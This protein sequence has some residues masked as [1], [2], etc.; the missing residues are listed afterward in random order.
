MNN[1]YPNLQ[2]QVRGNEQQFNQDDE[3]ENIDYVEDDE[4]DNVQDNNNQ[5]YGQNIR[6]SKYNQDVQELPAIDIN[7][8]NNY[9]KPDPILEGL[10]V[11]IIDYSSKTDWGIVEHVL[12]QIKSYKRGRESDFIIVQR[13]YSDFEWL[14][15]EFDQKYIGII[16]PPLPEKNVLSKINFQKVDLIKRPEFLQE[17]LICLKAFLKKV[18]DHPKLSKTKEFKSFIRDSDNDFSKFKEKSF[19][20]R[21]SANEPIGSG[22]IKKFYNSVSTGLTTAVDYISGT[23]QKKERQ[24]TKEDEKFENYERYYQNQKEKI[25]ETTR[26]LHHIFEFKKKQAENMT[27]FSAIL[28]QLKSQKGV[29]ELKDTTYKA[30]EQQ[31]KN[32]NDLISSIEGPLKEQIKHFDS[33]L[34]ILSHR[35][36]LLLKIF[37]NQVKIEQLLRQAGKQ[38]EIDNLRDEVEN[39]ERRLATLQYLFQEDNDYFKNMIQQQIKEILQSF[40]GKSI[41]HSQHMARIWQNSN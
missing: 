34:G 4:N 8:L 14:V 40:S 24:K 27:Q 39:D 17:R 2:D 7:T 12:Y 26:C 6:N 37:D 33:C 15:K 32:S 23:R 25:S 35:K 30:S 3:Y 5:Q 22:M 36:E 13:R 20:Q 38:D 18:L 41:E 19:T 21:Q 10:V 9:F 11:D 28:D 29:S 16:I 1:K 31:A